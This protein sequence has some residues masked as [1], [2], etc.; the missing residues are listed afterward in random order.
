VQGQAAGQQQD[1]RNFRGFDR[2]GKGKV[3]GCPLPIHT[4]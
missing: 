4:N 2:P 1:S 3:I